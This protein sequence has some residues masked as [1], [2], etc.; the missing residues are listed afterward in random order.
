[1]SDVLDVDEL[2]GPA[3]ERRFAALH[4]ELADALW[5]DRPGAAE[6]LL[7]VTGAA[8]FETDAGTGRGDSYR[9]AQRDEL[10]RRRG[11]DTLLAL[12][13]PVDALIEPGWRLLDVL[14]GDGLL[15]R[16]VGPCAGAT[17]PILTSDVAEAMVRHALAYGLP[18]IRQA[19]HFLLLR[20]A[21][22]DAVL[23]A[24]GTHHI[25]RT[26]RAAAVAEAYRVLRPAGRVLLH[27]FHEGGPVARFFAEIVDRWSAAGHRYEHFNEAEML[28]YLRQVGFSE[29]EVHLVYD[30]LVVAGATEAD[31]IQGLLTYMLDMYG[32]RG[33]TERG[34]DGREELLRWLRVA[35]RYDR[36]AVGPDGVTEL[37]VR[38]DARGRATAE[39]PRV[40]LVA[41]GTRGPETV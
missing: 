11:M 12:V 22:V 38:T 13:R 10:V 14:G 21:S 35:M 7:R 37:T 20:D 31:A 25:A 29:T 18:A 2:D 26:Q 24:Y 3:L 34:P 8:E 28:G 9:R 4:P 1:M 39:L 6:E 36:D 5:L 40:A 17:Y 32:L 19:A 16:V 41:T 27:D 33:L 30:P 23:L 15:A